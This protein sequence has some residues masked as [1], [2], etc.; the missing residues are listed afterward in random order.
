[1]L[2]SRWTVKT[3]ISAKFK[4]PKTLALAVNRLA[5][6]G[7]TNSSKILGSYANITLTIENITIKLESPT[8]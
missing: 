7:E 8:I 5:K 6:E 4:K 2:Q 3:E 1:M